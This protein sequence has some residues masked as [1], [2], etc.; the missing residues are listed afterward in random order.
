MRT[1]LLVSLALLTASTAAAREAGDV[2]IPFNLGANLYS[3]R[4]AY[5]GKKESDST[6]ADRFALS[7]FVGAGYFVSDRWRL[8]LN[9]QFSEAIT[10]PYPAPA[11][12]FTLFGFLL[13]INY[14]FWGPLTASIVPTFLV[15]YE[16]VSQFA[17]N[18]QA[19]LAW[20]IPLRHGFS[21]NL[22]VEVPVYIYP[23]VSV[24]ITPLIGFTYG[25]STRKHAPPPS[26]P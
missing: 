1:I 15:W 20:G 21:L 5:Y 10:S 14:N 17:F 19:V 22:A 16:G 11:S 25:M 8:G 18:V 3:H 7:E 2:T 12:S 9:L 26:A 23:V 13:Q 6:I 4:F 24:G